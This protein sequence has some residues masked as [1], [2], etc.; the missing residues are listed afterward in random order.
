M[1]I[2]KVINDNYKAQDSSFLYY[3]HEENHFDEE[4]LSKLCRCISSLAHKNPQDRAFPMQTSFIYSQTLKHIIYHF[5]PK[6]SYEIADLPFDYNEK[7]ELLDTA[8][9]QYFCADSSPLQ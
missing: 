8:V 2:Q 3:L 6:D 1:D 4:A 5:D 7:L 9:M